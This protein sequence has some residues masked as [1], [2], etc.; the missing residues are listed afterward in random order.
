MTTLLFS[1]KEWFK[2]ALAVHTLELTFPTTGTSM[3]TGND[4]V[5]KGAYAFDN[6]VQGNC[7][8]LHFSWAME[9]SI[10]NSV[11]YAKP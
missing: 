3:S 11:R 2:P 10:S 7:Y 8:F 4:I 1:G 9:T 6:D 5:A